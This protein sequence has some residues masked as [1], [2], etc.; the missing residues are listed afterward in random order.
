MNFTW[1]HM[2]IIGIVALVLGGAGVA[3]FAFTRVGLEMKGC[4]FA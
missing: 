3:G 2:I 4:L 1:T